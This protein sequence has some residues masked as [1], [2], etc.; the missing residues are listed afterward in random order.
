MLQ[1]S[2]AIVQGVL[3]GSGLSSLSPSGGYTF[4]TQATV[5][6]PSPPLS[7]FFASPL[8]PPPVEVVDLT[9]IKSMSVKY[10]DKKMAETYGSVN[11]NTSV[12]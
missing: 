3:H 2:A 7:L 12:P 5:P 11:E 4:F 6:L 1:S 8:P 9:A 10:F